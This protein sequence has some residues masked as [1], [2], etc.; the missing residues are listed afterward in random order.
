MT[1]DPL[2]QSAH[3]LLLLAPMQDITDLAFMQVLEAFGGG[4][5]IYVTEYFRVH[6][7]SR[8]E[9]GILRMI[10]ENSSGKPVIAQMIGCSIPDLVRTAKELEQHAVAGVDLNLGCPA[11][12]VYRKNAGGG[13]LRDLGYL[14]RLLGLLRAAIDGRFT[15]KTRVGFESADEFAD[16]LAVFAKHDIDALSIHGRTV[17]ERYATP[18]HTDCIREAVDQLSCPVLANG[19]VVSVDTGQAMLQQT[20]AA[21][22][23]IGRG[24]IRNPWLFA[25]L[26][27]NWE[28]AAAEIVQPTLADVHAYVEALYLA[29]QSLEGFD[30]NKHVQKMK[31]YMIFIAQSVDDGGVFEHAIRRVSDPEAFWRVCHAALGNAEAWPAE[32]PPLSSRIFCGFD[33]LRLP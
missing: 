30:E 23:M 11:P 7:D 20:G 19:N 29:T 27:A 2:F 9:K 33:A 25:Q 13:L 1:A 24:A 22:L 8:L 14:D 15:V 32:E 6:V 21:G 10:D 31:K 28:G 12:V 17:A 26:R 18:V 5:D 3:P 16:L 4:P